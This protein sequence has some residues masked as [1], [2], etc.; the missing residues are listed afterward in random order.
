V[1][2]TNTN[3]VVAT[4][5]LGA[6]SPWDVGVS[7]NGGRV[8]VTGSGGTVSVINTMTLAVSR[9]YAA[10]PAATGIAVSP[11]GS[12]LYVATELWNSNITVMDTSPT[13][14]VIGTVFVGES[15]YPI[16]GAFT[17]DGKRLYMITG[18]Q[19]EAA[20]TNG[21][22][23]MV[24]DTDPTSVTYNQVISTLTDYDLGIGFPADVVLSPDGSRAY[25]SDAWGN[26][27]TVID[28]STNTVIG[29]IATALSP[30]SGSRHMAISPDGNTLYITDSAAGSV[31]IVSVA[32]MT[33]TAL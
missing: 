2:N 17:L 8:Y 3:T 25:V 13:M 12:R 11:D 27:V 24:I 33:P 4:I 16:D 28:T 14:P 5:N 10:G 32:S 9:P 20:Q 29:T 22:A 31:V 7:P 18:V 15:Y 30:A 21:P 23:V 19:G 1:I 26:T 6:I